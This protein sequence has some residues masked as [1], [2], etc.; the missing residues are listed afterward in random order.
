MRVSEKLVLKAAENGDLKYLKKV[1]NT[2]NGF[3]KSLDWMT[4]VDKKGRA[5]LHLSSMNGHI[6]IVKMIWR[7]MT[8]FTK[9]IYA[10]SVYL[11]VVDNKGRTA[12]FH[13]AAG[14]Y[15]NICNY[16]VDR[17]AN[18]DICTNENHVS[19]GST[20]LMACAEKGH[21]DC[22]KMLF[23]KGADV[24]KLRKDGADAIYMAARYGNH[25]IV[26]LIATDKLFKLIVNRKSFHGRTALITA[27]IHGHLAV[28]Q[29]L[30]ANGFDLDEQDNDGFTALIHATN[31]GHYSLVKWL[32][33]SGANIY[34]KDRYGLTA[35]NIAAAKSF[36]DIAGFLLESQEDLERGKKRN[37][38]LPS[39]SNDKRKS[40]IPRKEDG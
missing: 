35:W 2:D 22:F 11:D 40:N 7:I 15:L 21:F 25:E 37:V 13:A 38:G 6:N 1:V 10:R 12:L 18:K 23:R 32:V 4:K 39:S 17:H 5:P 20:A 27:A 34:L 31:A 26:R 36:S 16:L 9:D 8:E 29:V 28:C 30:H 24:I 3:E 19:P 33:T 14:G